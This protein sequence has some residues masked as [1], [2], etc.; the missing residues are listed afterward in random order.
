[1]KYYD[2]ISDLIGK[3]PLVRINKINPFPET[4]IL[5]KLERFNPGGSV[6]DRVAKSMLDDAENKGLLG[7]DKIVLES[8]SGNT[9]IGLAMLC[10]L[11]GY[12]CELVMPE[13]MSIERRMIMTAYGAKVTLTPAGE[14][15]DGARDYV[16]RKLSE[17]PERYFSPNQ[18]DNPANWKAH[19]ENTAQ[20]II[21]D[22]DGKITHFVAGLGTSGTLM[23]V[24]RGLKERLADVK[25]VSVEPQ[26][27]SFIQGLRDLDVQEIPLIFDE[28]KLD[29]RIR[30][31]D[32][33]AEKTTKLLGLQEGIF[34]G[35][36]SGAATWG[37]IEVAR[38][39]NE[40]GF[41]DGVIVVMLPDSGERYLSNNQ[42]SL[43]ISSSQ[44]DSSLVE[45]LV[46]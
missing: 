35:L 11:K 41:S 46:N 20:E 43:A 23:G 39:L 17:K 29:R 19:F 40:S 33:D 21:E 34:S 8:T 22:T 5:A 36:S 38:E 42:Y 26:T 44:T 9:G 6:K 15:T 30:V 28:S 25:I 3:T 37:A 32:V 27:D 10:A 4:L 16:R 14:G 7:P 12:Q 45:F 18:Y 2:K 1:M 31:S 13:S 24:A